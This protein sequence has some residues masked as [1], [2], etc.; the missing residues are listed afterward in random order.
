VEL[1]F[2]VTLFV[3]LSI[4][5]GIEFFF[6]ARRRAALREFAGRFGLEYSPTDLFGLIDHRFAL[7]NQADGARCDNVVWGT[8]HGVDV[9]VGELRFKSDPEPSKLGLLKATRRFS[10]AVVELDAWVP[11]IAIRHDPLASVSET[12]LLDRLRFESDAFNRTYRVE[13]DDPRF[14]YKVVDA[15]M[16]LWLQEIGESFPF[17][18]EANGDRALVSCRRLKPSGLVPLFGAAKGFVDHIPSVVL[19]DNGL[20]TPGRSQG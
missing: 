6:S 1:A 8:W 16:M 7:F 18:F 11:R 4:V 9:K 17:D 10:F 14:A 12:L 2:Y 5:A 13:C 20:R 15:R 19:R 3:L